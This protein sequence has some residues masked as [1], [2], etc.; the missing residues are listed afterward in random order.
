MLDQLAARRTEAMADN[1]KIE[2]TEATWNPVT[3]CT[4][5]SPGCDNCYAETFAERFRGVPQHHFEQ[6]FDVVLRPERLDQPL[7]WKRPRRVFTNSMSDLFHD[8]V[9]DDFIAKMFAVMAAAPQHTFQVLTKR[10]GRMRTLLSSDDFR[11]QV[12]LASNLPHGDVLGDGWPLRN[13]W[14]G[15][16]VESQK[17][18]DIRIPALLETTAAVRWLSCEPLLGPLDLSEWLDHAPWH[19][20]DFGVVCSCGAAMAG[21]ER[22]AAPSLEWIVVGGESGPGA[23]PMHPDWARSLRDHCQD[24][25]VPYFFKQFGQ[26]APV[27]D[28]PADGDL[29]VPADG[30][31]AVPWKPWD[32]HVRAGGGDFRSPGGRSV[33]MRR[34]RSKHDAGRLLDGR[35]WSECPG[36]EN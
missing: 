22:C 17:W 27:V 11:E 29:W 13:V 16:S 5:V 19:Y 34:H 32:G 12:F 20:T 8:A 23:R 14:L 4:K 9:P 6:G 30:S 25:E 2:W 3:G 7:R 1:S 15:V 10:H 31:G 21:D 33:L 26:H 18:A 35:E 36:R 28:Q 24:S